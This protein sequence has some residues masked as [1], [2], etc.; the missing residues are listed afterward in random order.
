MDSAH[1]VGCMR[2]P[3]RRGGSLTRSAVGRAWLIAG[4][5]ARPAARLRQGDLEVT[6]VQ[7]H[8]EVEIQGREI[9]ELNLH[10][11]ENSLDGFPDCPY[12]ARVEES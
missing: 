2:A 4:W 6:H 10:H 12:L 1:S 5:A 7:G 8:Q 11:R 3:T 9:H